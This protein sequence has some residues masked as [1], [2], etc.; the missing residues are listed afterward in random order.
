[1]YT[2]FETTNPKFI[3][4]CRA[5]STTPLLHLSMKPRLSQTPPLVLILA[6]AVALLLGPGTAATADQA[7][8]ADSAITTPVATTQ[9][10]I[11]PCVA[12]GSPSVRPATEGGAVEPEA[13]EGQTNQAVDFRAM[14]RRYGRDATGVRARLGMCRKGENGQSGGPHRRFRGGDRWNTP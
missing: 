5:L 4:S 7:G 14:K 10:R 13:V 12:N 8:Q 2:A 9:E 6:L 11:P 1:M 3:H